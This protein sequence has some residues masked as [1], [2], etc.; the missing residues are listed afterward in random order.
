MWP[1]KNPSKRRLERSW[2]RRSLDRKIPVPRSLDLEARPHHHQQRNDYLINE[3]S[4]D[5]RQRELATVQR[6]SPP[7]RQSGSH[8]IRL[9]K[10]GLFF[11][12]DVLIPVFMQTI[13]DLVADV[14]ESNDLDV[15]GKVRMLAD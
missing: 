9:E 7:Y 1:A 5:K 13:D 14:A 8:V 10:K 15:I 4:N 2:Q 3:D 12:A 6:N 11:L